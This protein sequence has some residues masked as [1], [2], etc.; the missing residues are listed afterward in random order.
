MEAGQVLHA[1][2]AARQSRWLPPNLG[3][4]GLPHLPR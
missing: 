4:C 2:G 3:V 1:Q